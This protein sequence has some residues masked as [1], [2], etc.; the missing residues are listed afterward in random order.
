MLREELDRIDSVPMLP[1]VAG[2]ILKLVDDPLVTAHKLAEVVS[3]DQSLVTSVLRVVNSAYYGFHWRI[4]SVSQAVVLLGFRTIRNLVL[5]AAVMK[6]YGGRSRAAGF[7]RM[8]HW[9]HSIGCGSAAAVLAGRWRLAGAGEA[10]L[11]GLVHDIGRVIMDQ[12]FPE[13]FAETLARSRSG[14]C[15]LIEAEEQVFGLTHAAVGAHVA[16]KW[17]LP[18][19]VISGIADHHGPG[20]ERA[21]SLHAALVHAAD[22]MARR[23][24]LAVG[25]WE[26]ELDPGALAVLGREAAEL[27]ALGEPFR[28]EYERSNVFEILVG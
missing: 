7:D 24:G 23:A 21:W 1:E 27:D 26:M 8:A 9:R 3:R 6:N 22:V 2:R 11:A 17:K 4:S 25:T 18:E 14:P 15:S 12:H 28:E 19:G 13:E 10:F 16:R 20:A 5:A